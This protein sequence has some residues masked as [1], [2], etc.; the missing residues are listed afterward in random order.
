MK[1]RKPLELCMGILLIAGALAL[2]REV[3]QV[4][5][6]NQRAAKT[7][8]VDAG[9]GGSDPGMV[10]EELKEKDLNL[11]IAK[12]LRTYLEKEGFYVEM[13][14]TE[15]KGLYQ[16][17]SRNKKAQDMQNRVAFIAEK[18][19]LLTVSIHQNSYPDPSVKGPQVFYYAD[20]V[21]GEKLA[22]CIQSQMNDKLET[23]P[24]REAKGNTSYYLLKKS[25]GVLNIIEC[26]FMTNPQEAANLQEKGYQQKVVEAIG[27]GITDYLQGKE[28]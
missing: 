25:S 9:H 11:T 26:G 28:E 2:S 7:I 14:R 19:P 17:G 24:P 10:T 27:S 18:T 4:V 6:R 15:D 16:E 21:E 1:S 13:T 20:S 22:G 5:S 3:V 12:M 23:E 8:V